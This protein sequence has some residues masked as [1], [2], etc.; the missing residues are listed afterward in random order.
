M[1][2]LLFGILFLSLDILSISTSIILTFLI[3]FKSLEMF[4]S[5][6]LPRLPFDDIIL[7]AIFIPVIFYILE[8]Y[9]LIFYESGIKIIQRIL[10]GVFTAGILV[11]VFTYVFL[12]I[13]IGRSLFA[14][15]IL[16]IVTFTALWRIIF[17]IIQ[18]QID[19]SRNIIVVGPKGITS[20][21]ADELMET[22]RFSVK[23]YQ[24]GEALKNRSL[25]QEV[26][27][28]KNLD[29]IFLDDPKMPDDVM[30]DL[31]QCRVKGIP[32]REVVDFYEDEWEKIPVYHLR[33]RWFVYSHGFTVIHHIFYQRVKRIIDIGL[34]I[35]TMVLAGPL[36]FLTAVLIK[37]ESKGPI[38]YKQQR[39]GLNEKTYNLM[40]FR[41]MVRDAEKSGAVWAKK[42]D[43]RLTKIGRIIRPFRIDELPQLIN[44]LKG[45]MSFI[46]PRP[47]RPVFIEELKKE[48][49]YY[50]YRHLVKPGLT[51]WAQVNYPY[52]ASVE[53]AVR[54]LG[55]DLYYI[56]NSNF[57]LDLQIFLRTL[58]VILLRKGSR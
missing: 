51:G 4:F 6:Q 33:D 1:R 19:R 8:L 26:S 48:I 25:L 37:I 35:L 52:G 27:E 3:K 44:I 47:E 24:Y 29:V 46:G 32:V 41:S 18:G 50:S 42:K 23:K 56:K 12:H 21:I 16:F 39:V 5:E 54:K 45:N 30:Q 22:K 7:W 43:S 14:L 31:M 13:F 20:S 17:R 53:D 2:K 10:T 40:K 36:M 55:Y 28:T 15:H 9:S 49:P 57:L 11:A 34:S 58:R 38:L